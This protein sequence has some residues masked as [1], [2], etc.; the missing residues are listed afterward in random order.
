MSTVNPP[1]SYEAFLELF[2]PEEYFRL[3]AH[4]SD[5]RRRVLVSSVSVLAVALLAVCC[6]VLSCSAPASARHAAAARHHHRHRYSVSHHLPD[7][8]HDESLGAVI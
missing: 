7:A 6:A 4:P 8:D 1:G 2:A 5:C 3:V